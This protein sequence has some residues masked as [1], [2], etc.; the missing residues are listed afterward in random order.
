MFTIS[1]QQPAADTVVEHIAAARWSCER[2]VLSAGDR[3]AAFLHVL[4]S[5]A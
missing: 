1:A 4:Q 5:S 3:T 2:R